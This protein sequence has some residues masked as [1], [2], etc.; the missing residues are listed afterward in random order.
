[1]T[2]IY[3]VIDVTRGKVA[4]SAG[5]AEY[6]DCISVEEQGSLNECPGYDTKQFESEAPVMQ[7]FGR[8]RCTPFIAIAPR[9]TMTRSGS[10]WY[11][12]IY[13][14]SRT[15]LCTYVKLKCLKKKLCICVRMG[16]ALNKIKIDLVSYPARAEAVG[17]YD[18]VQDAEHVQFLIG[19]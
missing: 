4:L 19:V 8:M 10:T 18:H 11:G 6:T 15:N 17:K 1:M 2:T 9:F 7:E 3:Y 16:L 14:L 13:R 12:P 5:A